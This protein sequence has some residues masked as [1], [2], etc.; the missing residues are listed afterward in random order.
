MSYF[1]KTPLYKDLRLTLDE[2]LE[3]TTDPKAQSVLKWAIRKID[4]LVAESE[5]VDKCPECDAGTKQHKHG[6]SAN[7]VNGLNRLYDHA[8]LKFANLKVLGLGRVQWDNF[9]K[10]KYWGLVEQKR[11]KSGEWRVTPRGE[12]FLLGKLKVPCSV[13]TYRGIFVEYE[14]DDIGPEDAIKGWKH[15]PQYAEDAVPT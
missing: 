14:G 3:K 13:I 11:I 4:S 7:I 5:G 12:A 15:R 9:Q 1:E 2:T 6:L 8:G 10:L